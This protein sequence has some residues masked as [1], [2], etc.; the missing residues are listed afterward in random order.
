MTI[1]F[2]ST[3]S[4][5]SFKYM[6]MLMLNSLFNQDLNNLFE[7]EFHTA[8]RP[9]CLETV[10]HKKKP[11]CVLIKSTSCSDLTKTTWHKISLAPEADVSAIK[12][13]GCGCNL[14]EY[15]CILNPHT[16]PQTVSRK[17]VVRMNLFILSS[18]LSCNTNTG[19]NSRH[20]NIAEHQNE[21]SVL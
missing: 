18:W 17:E 11:V 13:S 15:L 9:I 3:T 2:S 8:S 21:S 10:F 1:C 19:R 16:N 6:L 20:I 12:L 14:F 4:S 5:G 7:K